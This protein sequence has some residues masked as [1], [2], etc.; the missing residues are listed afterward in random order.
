[1]C[2]F[3]EHAR[4]VRAGPSG[5]QP[6]PAL[7]PARAS[8][9]RE[10]GSGMR[11]TVGSSRPAESPLPCQRVGTGWRSYLAS[12]AVEG[13]GPK[14]AKTIVAA[15]GEKTFDIL[16]REP[17]RL[18]ALDGIGSK[19]A[20]TIA[21][22]WTEKQNL[23]EI[24]LFLH[25]HGVGAARAAVIYKRYGD[26]TISL[27]GRTPYRLME[28]HGIGFLTADRVALSVGIARNAPE[29]LRAGVTYAVRT[30]VERQGALRHAAGRAGTGGGRFAGVRDTGGRERDFLRN[31]SG[32][33]A[34]PGSDRWRGIRVS[35]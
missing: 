18:Q 35:A 32:W 11:S 15:F 20:A 28:I 22:S 19:R 7:I 8:G 3:C 33:R 1:M 31:Q 12:G 34:G 10:A 23:R 4:R 24:L 29:R 6:P 13:I 17:E 30:A 2:A 26:D 5:R 14:T 9:Q 21:A 25:S 16:S 27:V